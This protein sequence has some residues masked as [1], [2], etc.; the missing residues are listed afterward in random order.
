MAQKWGGFYFVNN[1]TTFI[2]LVLLFYT[3]IKYTIY[4]NLELILLNT[5]T[6]SKISS[7]LKNAFF[8]EEYNFITEAFQRLFLSSKKKVCDFLEKYKLLVF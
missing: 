4:T 1:I 8:C 6:I 5:K 7:L 2:I 3:S